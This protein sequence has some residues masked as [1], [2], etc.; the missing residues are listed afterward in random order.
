MRNQEDIVELKT[1]IIPPKRRFD[2]YITKSKEDIEF[3]DK[4]NKNNNLIGDFYF[5]HND[6]RK[7]LSRDFYLDNSYIFTEEAK[8][9]TIQPSKEKYY[10][11]PNVDKSFFLLRKTNA[12]I[13]KSTLKQRVGPASCKFDTF[14][15]QYKITCHFMMF[16]GRHFSSLENI[17]PVERICI[18]SSNKPE[19]LYLF[20]LLNS[21][22]NKRLLKILKY[23]PNE[24]NFSITLT[25][26]KQFI[27]VPKLETQEQQ[28]RKQKIIELTEEML[29]C[30]Q[31][32]QVV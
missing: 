20:S 32:E 25:N 17:M 28:S 18:T 23:N 30:E 24:R 2:Y 4:Y 3:L 19:A 6:P 26:I 12:F 29:N 5:N 9:Y 22:T 14:V 27:R 15:A 13:Q 31:E 16:Q 10:N 11:V 7:P 21:E 8:N 1:S